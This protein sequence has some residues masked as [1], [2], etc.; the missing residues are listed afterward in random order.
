MSRNSYYSHS[1]ASSSKRRRS[2]SED[3]GRHKRRNISPT[4]KYS[5]AP[6]EDFSFE[7][8]KRD[9][10]K[11]I[12]YSSESNTVGN[13]LDDFWVFLKKY[14]ATLRKAG[15]PI[16]D[17]QSYEKYEVNDIGTPKEFSKFHC[18]NFT[19][20]IKYVDTVQDDKQRRKLDKK[21]FDAFMNIVSIYLDFKNKEKFEKL[22]KLR[23]TQ[24]E[25]PVA[26]YRNEITAAVQNER[27]VIVAGD[28]GCGKSTQVPQYL[29][30]AGFQNIACTQPRRIACVSLSKRVAFE[31]L[32]QFESKVGYQ[33]RFEKSKTADT[34]I[35]FITEGLLLRQMSSENLPNYDVIILDEIHERHLMGDFLLGILKCLIHSRTDIKLV[36]MSATI[37]IKLFEDYF[38]KEKAVVIQVPGRLF[39]IELNYKPIFIEDKP[40]RDDRLD[41]QPY[42]QIMQLIDNKY[43]SDERGDMLI[44]MSGVQEITAICDAAQQYA[45]KTK[46][47]I[48]LPLHSGLSLAEQDKVFDYPPEGVRKCIVSTNIAETSVTIDGIRF[49]VDSGKVKEMSYDSTTK[50]QRLKEFWI[51]QASADQR[52]GRA[53]RTGPGVC[54]R[55]YSEK[56]FEDLEPFSTPEVSRVPLA[57][58]LLLM[59]SLGVND[60]RRFPFLDAPPEDGVENALLELKQHGALTYNE[61]LT[62]LGR[63]LAN[64]PVEV[65]LAKAIVIGA[66]TLPPHK[67]DSALALAAALGI[68][69]IYTTRAHRDF[70]CE[71]ARKPDESD[72]GDPL[73]LLSLYC[74]WLAVKAEGGGGRAWCRRRALE[75]QRL[76]ELTKLQAQLTNL[77]QDN[78]LMET[79]EPETM[80]SAERAMRHGQLK[81]L[82]DMRRQYKQKAA[83]DSKRKKRLKV[84]SYEI[85]DEKDE[86]DGALDI[87]DIEFRMT[88][89]AKRIQALISGASTSSGRDLIMLKIVLCRAL[90]PQIAVADEFNHFK[91]GADQLYHTWS[92]PFV[93]LHPTSYFG[94]NPRVLQLTEGDIQTDAPLGFKSKLPLS[95]KHQILCYLSL[96]ETTKPYIVNSMR[97]P[98]AQT[99]LLLAHTID[100]NI[101]FTRIVCDS[102]LLLEF[103]YPESGLNLLLKAVK[104]RQRWDALINRR[105]NDANPNKSVEAELQKNQPRE[106]YEELQHDLSCDIS[107]YMSAEVYYT[108]KRLLPGDLKV[109]YYGADE[110]HPSI[111]PNPFEEKFECR[112]HD[113]KGGVYVTDNVVYNCVVDTD[114]SYNSYQETYALPW[115]CPD[116][117]ISLCFSPL[118]RLQH[119]QF[120]CSNRTEKKETETPKPVKDNRPNAKEYKCETCKETLYMTPVEI[121][122]HKKSCMVK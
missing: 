78:N 39:P 49:V 69:S 36:L 67:R 7:H 32:T 115:T 87:R 68:R 121:L 38:S 91:S 43:P 101:G 113:K 57:S 86:E 63:V 119:K 47:W 111:D 53:G 120:T 71:N 31:M 64:L 88:N 96:L 30:D 118:E 108:I 93:Y 16:V 54:Y 95:A 1:R 112:P 107:A 45:E 12:L 27:V 15:K 70:D 23:Q 102:W 61:K 72:H 85:V 20:K 56:Q 5:L 105:L 81:Q 80:S 11:I 92:K 104:L 13:S 98:A 9:L 59:S 103:P 79:M 18:I 65:S 97:M 42:V 41:P 14:E 40:T 46:N 10:N 51:S 110:T 26:K 29:H 4:S 48:V 99:L 75:D 19:T 73:T 17:Y 66:A 83:E 74:G 55:I 106:S 3:R 62:S 58:L 25:L 76:Y 109:L 122:R 117:G 34:K 6:D 77:L 116:C 37:N 94:K 22:K 21:L 84:D 89:D 82:K 2:H 50:M 35:C 52:K 60:V 114:W 44:F 28:T 8:Y 90:Y 33:I 24:S 100:T